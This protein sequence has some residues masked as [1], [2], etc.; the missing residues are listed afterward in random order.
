MQCFQYV[1]LY[2]VTP[3]HNIS[4]FFFFFFCSNV[5]PPSC[6][7]MGGVIQY[8][9]TP[10]FETILLHTWLTCCCENRKSGEKFQLPCV[11]L[12]CCCCWLEESQHSRHRG[13]ETERRVVELH[14]EGVD[15]LL[16]K[17]IML[18]SSLLLAFY[19][20]VKCCHFIMNTIKALPDIFIILFCTHPHSE[21]NE[22]KL[23][24]C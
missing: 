13:T 18:H 12:F 16:Y 22:Q 14:C 23:L 20:T 9:W 7:A 21:N 19:S 8:N 11:V 4:T 10:T 5:T 3:H 24:L 15:C 6:D 2:V 1:Q 17:H